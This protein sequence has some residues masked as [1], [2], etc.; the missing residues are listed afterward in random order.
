MEIELGIRKERRW[1]GIRCLNSLQGESSLLVRRGKKEM[2]RMSLPLL[3]AKD[4]AEMEKRF[5]YTFEVGMRTKKMQTCEL[6]GQWWMH[7]TAMR[8]DLGFTG[9]FFSFVFKCGKVY[10]MCNLPSSSFFKCTVH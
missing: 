1:G 9:L 3:K 4:H 6:L 8:V 5:S 7:T 2:G 10:I